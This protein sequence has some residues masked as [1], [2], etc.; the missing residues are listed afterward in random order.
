MSI[1]EIQQHSDRQ[2]VRICPPCRGLIFFRG[3]ARQ[4]RTGQSNE[5]HGRIHRENWI[6]L[7]HRIG[8]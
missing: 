8:R 4:V 2:K 7:V 6:E 1:H 3:P 5:G